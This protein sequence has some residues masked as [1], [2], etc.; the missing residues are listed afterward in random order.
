MT[1]PGKLSVGPD[2]KV[3]ARFDSAVEPNSKE[4]TSAVEK[5]LA[6]LT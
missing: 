5:A 1:G 4:L 6:S 3:I 2:G